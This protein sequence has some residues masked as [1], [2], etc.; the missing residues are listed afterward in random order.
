MQMQTRLMALTMLIVALLVTA[1]CRKAEPATSTSDAMSPLLEEIASPPAPRQDPST[2]FPTGSGRDEV[3]RNCHSCHP[4]A[5]AAIRGRS[6]AEW[7]Q[8]R[9]VHR[10]P[11]V[12]GDIDR[13]F[14]YLELHFDNG[15]QA[16]RVSVALL[17]GGCAPF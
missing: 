7:Q 14:D 15:H 1:T 6:V 16:A 10:G 17:E 9:K 3:L 12:N 5:C 13:A 11:S 2:L 4:I 8:L